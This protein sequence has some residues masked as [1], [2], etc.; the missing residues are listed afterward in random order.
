MALEQFQNNELPEEVP[1]E[2]PE[3]PKQATKEKAFADDATVRLQQ[4]R[5]EYDVHLQN[6]IDKAS[7]RQLNYN[8]KL[9]ALGAGLLTPGK[10]GNFFE[11]LG[12]G[13]KGYM[14]AGE[15]EVQTEMERAKLE[16]ELRTGQIGQL[17]KDYV[18]Q[19]DLEGKQ[20]L[21]DVMSGKIDESGALIKPTTLSGSDKMTVPDA[22]ALINSAKTKG[23]RITPAMLAAAPTKET[24]DFLEKIVDNQ[25]KES[26]LEQKEFGPATRLVSGEEMKLNVGQSRE[27]RILENKT[28]DL[29]REGK[30]TSETRDQIINQYLIDQKIVKG[31]ATKAPEET[32]TKTTE[33]T[34]K[35]G[36]ETP[37]DITQRREIEKTQSVEDIKASKDVQKKDIANIT[38]ETKSAKLQEIAARDMFTFANDPAFEKMFG[39]LNSK[40]GYTSAFFLALK[41]PVRIGNTSIGVGQIED[42]LRLANVKDPSVIAAAERFKGLSKIIEANETRILLG[43]EGQITEGERKIVT[44]IVPTLSDPK[45]VVKAK[46]EL[47]IARSQFDQERAKAFNAYVRQNKNA[48]YFDFES[49]PESPYQKLWNDYKNHT[50]DIADSYSTSGAKTKRDTSVTNAKPTSPAKSGSLWEAIQRAKEAE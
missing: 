22:Y 44:T 28:L 30:M 38:Q 33:G 50:A 23:K 42:I 47:T 37:A 45:E 2:V 46:A 49:N 27:L 14:E 19:K 43:G 25:Q 3:A 10:T 13:A 24:R 17:E 35:Q 41:E 34:T 11:G 15:K 48:T 6:L 4:K 39:I 32:T 18:L 7:Q 1:A 26:E 36:F 20:F 12:L 21:R 5:R 8:P 40:P 16:N 29:V 31:T 9:L